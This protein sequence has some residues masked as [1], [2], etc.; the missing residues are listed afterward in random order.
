M[1]ESS[2]LPR[3]GVVCHFPPPPGG[4][5]VQAEAIVQGLVSEGVYAIPIAT[6]LGEAGVFSGLDNVR[7]LRTLLRGPVFLLRLL[8]ALPRVDVLHV[9]V[10]SGL[11]FFL[12]GATSILLGRA[13]GKRVILHYHSGNAPAFFDKCG[14]L[15]SSAVLSRVDRIVVPSEYLQRVFA[16]MGYTSTIVPNICHVDRFRKPPLP[17]S[18]AF[19]VARNLERIY[20]VDTILHAFAPVLARYS[21]A[22]LTVLGSGTQAHALQ[23]LAS[24]LGIEEAVTFTGS[25]SNS[26]IPELFAGSAIFVNAS[27]SDNQP[28]SI[29]EAFAAGLPVITSNV[30]GIPCLVRHGKTG[31]LVPPR[32]SAALTSAMFK[33]LEQP[34]LAVRCATEARRFVQ[35]YSWGAVSLQ[36]RVLYGFDEAKQHTPDPGL[37]IVSVTRTK[38]GA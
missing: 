21:E 12:F 28:V 2:A 27:V 29:L 5:P 17:L 33:M 14:S 37:N 30:G 24:E 15:V 22:R 32:D 38:S 31:L 36:L 26:T 4:M 11:Y 8:R 35:Q 16:A 7:F 3:V 20:G 23:C 1:N 10:C 25:V 13:T 34:G 18:P 6:N 19:I 9:N